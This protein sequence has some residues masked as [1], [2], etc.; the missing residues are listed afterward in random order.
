MV[1]NG[2]CFI[3]CFA[4]R[5]LVKATKE[6]II[7]VFDVCGAFLICLHQASSRKYVHISWFCLAVDNKTEV[8]QVFFVYGNKLG[9]AVDMQKPLV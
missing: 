3:I 2:V 6:E 5:K 7:L 8:E 9:R 4:F 1:L